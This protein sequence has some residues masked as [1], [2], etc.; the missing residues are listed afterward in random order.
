MS[1]D[2]DNNFS[3]TSPAQN[4]AEKIIGAT[5]ATGKL[6]FLMK[7]E[8]IDNF[9]LI[10]AE[11]A[12]IMYQEIVLNFYRKRL[13]ANFSQPKKN[14]EKSDESGTSNLTGNNNKDNEDSISEK[15]ENNVSETTPVQNIP[16][17]IVG[18]AMN[19]GQLMLL[20]KWVG[21]KEPNLISVEEA[22]LICPKLA[23]EFYQERLEWVH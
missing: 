17:K 8:G 11:E 13:T 21:T 6:M 9:D 19:G 18:S 14:V 7:W 1:V 16:E 22:H 5:N 20:V 23:I 4:K 2:I 15:I 3:K 10:T 12:N